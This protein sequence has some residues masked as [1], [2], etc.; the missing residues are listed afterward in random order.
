[1]PLMITIHPYLACLVH[2]GSCM[3]E[4]LDCFFVT[5]STGYAKW[6]RA[7]LDAC[8]KEASFMIMHVTRGEMYRKHSILLDYSFTERSKN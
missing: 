2:I 1:M 6:S 7:M 4:H 5:I 3:E 8:K